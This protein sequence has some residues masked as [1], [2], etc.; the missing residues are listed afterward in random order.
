MEFTPKTSEQ[1]GLNMV[2]E[3]Q[4]LADV[5]L[6]AS[7]KSRTLDLAEI[8]PI[9][10][11]KRKGG[12]ASVFLSV[13]GKDYTEVTGDDADGETARF[14]KIEN[15]SG[16]CASAGIYAGAG[17]V[18][19]RNHYWTDSFKRYDGWTGADGIYSFNI[20]NGRDNYNNSANNRTLFFFS[21][22]LVSKVDRKTLEREK[23]IFM[24]NNT[25]A[26]LDGE[27]PQKPGALQFYYSRDENGNPAGVIKP[28][29]ECYDFAGR[30]EDFEKAYF[31]LQDGVVLGNKLFFM[32]SIITEDKSGPEGFQFRG[33]GVTIAEADIIN[34]RP[35]L[36]NAVQH[37]AELWYKTD[38]VNTIYGACILPYLKEAGFDEG[39]GYVY[40]YGHMTF[41][42]TGRRS[43]CV[44]RVLPEHFADWTQ[45]RFFDGENFVEGIANS[46]PLLDHVSC[47]MSV[48][49]IAAGKN[50]GKFL[51]VFQYD[52]KSNYVAY[53][54]GENIW[55]PFS[56]PR[57]V[58]YCDEDQ[59]HKTVY[60]YNAK[61]HLHLS[62][63][64]KI[65]TTYNVNSTSA[66]QTTKN[67]HLYLP[68]FIE[69]EDTTITPWDRLFYAAFKIRT[70]MFRKLNQTA[71]PGQ[72]VFV[73]DSIINEYPLEEMLRDHMPVY[74]RGIGGD[75][76]KGLL[77]RL[78]ESIFELRP[79]K[80]FLL[81]GTNDLVFY[82]GEERIVE[83]LTCC[84]DEV[85]KNL[86]GCAIHLI[87]ILPVNNTEHPKIS[88]EAVGC[89]S[90]TIIEE[91]NLKLKEL[92]DSKNVIY[93]D[94]Y[95]R[96][97]DEQGNLAIEYTREGLHLSPR[98]YEIMTQVLAEFL[99]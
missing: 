82:S 40:I 64:D 73:G 31:W 38:E 22:T 7:E 5:L 66:E 44:S 46:K 69:L 83:N 26:L 75:T 52:T 77:T 88:H 61:A 94:V 36:E 4:L 3:N 43:L 98:G 2:Y 84:I 55:G 78:N 93:I 97:L 33:L 28:S 47:E 70:D 87:S 20:T 17:Y 13:D 37:K 10:K 95:N 67:G 23:P 53:A 25:Y 32:P 58:F 16:R 19:R 50:K 86:P 60:M 11:I 24:P 1:E 57:K 41:H 74:N 71:L 63:P 48:I 92:A 45:W 62:S 8:V 89:R 49:P 72:A 91:V 12:D 35:D 6:E 51:A 42:I 39:D 30:G 68:R 80:L 81:I 96:M 59:I 15:H 56:K 27:D 18:A 54:Y 14:I 90:N 85:R 29:R 21:D 65:L 99:G 76:T 34:G 9:G 79:S